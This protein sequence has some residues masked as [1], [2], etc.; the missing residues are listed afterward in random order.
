[1]RPKLFDTDAAIHQALQLFWANGY[2]GTKLPQLLD[3]MDL[4][5]ASFYNAFDSKHAVFLKVLDTYFKAVDEALSGALVGVN[6][7]EEATSRLLHAIVMV[8]R[9]P[10]AQASSWR[11]CLIGNS[12]LEMGAQDAAVRE[13]LG[14]G[15]HLLQQHFRRALSLASEHGNVL[16]KA[17]VSA[18]ALHAVAGIQGVL[19]LAKAGLSDSDIA[20]ALSSLSTSLQAQSTN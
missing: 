3:A 1:M 9:N 18:R 16:S 7:R 14:F 13:R 4:G 12:A 15:L 11:G 8:A 2:D 5:K 17:E 6:R 10:S 19:V 20:M